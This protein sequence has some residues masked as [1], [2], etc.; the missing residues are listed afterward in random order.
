MMNRIQM[1]RI[2]RINTD[3]KIRENSSNPLY[4]CAK[5]TI[6]KINLLK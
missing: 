6:K 4:L 3:N 1:T 2:K 5:N